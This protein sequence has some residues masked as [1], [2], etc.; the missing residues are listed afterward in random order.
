MDE[1]AQREQMKVRN[2]QNKYLTGRQGRGGA[3]YNVI[4]LKYEES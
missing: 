4:S 3:A 2:M 1:E